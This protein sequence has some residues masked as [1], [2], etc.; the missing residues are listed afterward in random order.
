MKKVL[1]VCVNFN[2]YDYLNAYI[3][4]IDIAAGKVTDVC[5][6]DVAVADN[7]VNNRQKINTTYANIKVEAFPYYKNLGYMGGAVK[8]LEDMGKES[9]CKF[10]FVIV[11]NVDITVKEGFFDSLV[12]TNTENIGWIAPAI[13]R[14]NNNMS[15]E[16]PFMTSK[17]SH[18]KMKIYIFM[19]SH[20]TLYSLY[21]YFYRY[22]NKHFG[23]NHEGQEDEKLEAIHQPIYA[24]MGS[25]F[26]FTQLFIKACYPLS[27]P[28][29]MYGEEL[30]FADAVQKAGLKTMYEPSLVVYDVGGV[31]TGKLG[32]SK[33]CKM[34]KES[35][36]I[37]ENILYT[38]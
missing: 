25:I 9:V 18:R 35:L 1:I 13:Y 29:F 31:S 19:Y 30:F 6:V 21:E 26:I 24:G 27:F 34:N 37:I 28:C 12:K 33:K 8:V 15:N 17:P 5:T 2:T 38:D 20:P 11:S 32:M 22:K 10:D 7:T 23:K 4:S 16:N 36:K 14:V 3:K